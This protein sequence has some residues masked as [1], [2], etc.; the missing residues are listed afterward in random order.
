MTDEFV[1]IPSNGSGYEAVEESLELSRTKPMGKLFK[2]HILNKGPLIHPVS[3]R[4][5]EIDDEFIRQL[6]MNF[7]N[8]V[9]DIVQV[10][11]A[12]DANQHSEDPLRNIGEVVDIQQE[13]DKVYA[14]IDI[15]DADAAPKMGK[16]LLGASALMSLNYVDTRTGKA[17][18]PTLLHTCVTNRPYVVGLDNYEEI[19]AATAD[20]TSSV[21]LLSAEPEAEHT[22][23]T[24]M[25]KTLDELLAQ[26]KEEHGIDVHALQASASEKEKELEQA[27][28]LSNTLSEEVKAAKHE[29]EHATETVQKLTEELSGAGVIKLTNGE[30]LSQEDIVGAVAEIAQGHLALSNQVKELREK[31]A[32]T[33]VQK[34]VDDGF[35]YPSQQKGMVTIKLSG[36]QELF[37]SLVPAKPVVEMNKET[38]VTP[39]DNNHELNVEEELAALTNENPQF[40]TRG[41]K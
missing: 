35:L 33:E 2:K 12:N 40:F 14:L 28:A 23:E 6:Q 11:L 21:V 27:T 30:E 20:N 32:K 41:T 31:D 19:V 25:P 16:T 7:H 10:P 8:G 24:E 22:E 37:D 4:K 26:L 34:L 15:R 5:I 36:D 13:G 9:C 3:K 17:A 38:G 29:A 1:I 39:E 18:G